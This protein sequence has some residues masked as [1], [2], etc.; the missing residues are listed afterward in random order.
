MYMYSD[1]RRKYSL[2]YKVNYC[3][4]QQK[5]AE[6]YNRSGDSP[7]KISQRHCTQFVLYRITQ[8]IFLCISK[9]TSMC[10]V[11]TIHEHF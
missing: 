10:A 1:I 8:H 4:R 9:A 7:F 2:E 6:K 5:F 3:E 11:G